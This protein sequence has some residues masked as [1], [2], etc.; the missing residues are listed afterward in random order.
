[1]LVQI[2]TAQSV[3]EA[4][5]LADLGV[6]HIGLTPA[7]RG[8]PGEISVHTAAAI[9]RALRDRSGAARPRSVALTVETSLEPVVDMAEAV[10]PDILHFCPPAGTIGPELIRAFRERVPGREVMYAVSVSGP[11]AVDE[12]ARFAEVADWF[13]LDTQAPDIPGVGASGAVHDWTISRRIVTESPIPVILAGGLSPE[14]VAE[15]IERVRP[16]GVDSL[17]HSNVALPEGG[18]RKDLDRVA[19]FVA[20]ARAAAQGR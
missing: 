18:F 6:D 8:L 3:P 4:L 16:A 15:A 14:N 5:A 1:M 19:S 11:E 7:N 20:K 13:I 9:V 12:A 2:Y 10:E 17:T